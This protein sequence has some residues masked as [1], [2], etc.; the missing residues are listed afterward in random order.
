MSTLES[1]IIFF[2]FRRSFSPSLLIVIYKNKP[3]PPQTQGEMH[4]L[5]SR[6][7]QFL[8]PVY[9]TCQPLTICAR[10][11]STW[12]PQL[13]YLVYF[14]PSTMKPSILPPELSKTVCFTPWAVFSGGFA[15]VTTGCYSDV[16]LLQ[17]PCF[18]F[19]FFF[20][21]FS[22]NFWK[23]IVNHRKIIKWKI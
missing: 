2:Y 12:S 9:R 21:L 3:K 1:W 6:L 11:K 18:E 7:Q 5:Q 22:V 13:S 16:V 10:K 15:T 20:N 23:I 17:C 19:S 4:L 14:T 8:L